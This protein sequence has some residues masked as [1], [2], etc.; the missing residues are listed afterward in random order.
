MIYYLDLAH[1]G[2]VMVLLMTG[3]YC[4]I[5]KKKWAKEYL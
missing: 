4:I 3:L 1:F 5:Q 2:L